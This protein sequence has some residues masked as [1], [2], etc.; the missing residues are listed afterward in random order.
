MIFLRCKANIQNNIFKSYLS[1]LH[2]N[3]FVISVSIYTRY[4]Y[5]LSQ[6]SLIQEY[7]ISPKG[8]NKKISS[9]TCGLKAVKSL[10][11]FRTLN[12]SI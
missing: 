12:F 9:H 4:I 8:L 10:K 7:G 3:A 5:S 11:N 2:F 1:F 6:K